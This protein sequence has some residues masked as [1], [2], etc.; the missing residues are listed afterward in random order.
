VLIADDVSAARE[1]LARALRERGHRVTAA[2]DGQE[3]LERF[4]GERPDA[5][6][7]DVNMP[8]LTGP[9]ACARM[10]ALGGTFVPTILI[11]AR[12]DLETRLTCLAVAEDFVTKPYDP[13]ELCARLEAH[14][15]TRRLVEEART[16]PGRVALPPSRPRLGLDP[17]EAGVAGESSK[18][19]SKAAV[20]GERRATTKDGV[21]AGVA[22]RSALLARLADEWK[23]SART[24]DPLALLVAGVDAAPAGESGLGPLAAALRQC[25]HALDVLARLDEQHLG[26]LLLGLHVTGAMAVAERLRREL[27]RPGTDGNLARVSMGIAV[28]PGRDVTEPGDLLHFAERALARAREEGA[29]RICIYQHASYL[30]EPG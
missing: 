9:E 15:R 10:K 12:T 6:I 21:L 11:S 30:Y 29:G 26:A 23:R 14:L 24:S 17:V 8:R 25:M 28:Y 16:R 7:L 13:G 4:Q 22:D 5:A 19:P 2:A 3:A 18:P 20:V 1:A 27:R